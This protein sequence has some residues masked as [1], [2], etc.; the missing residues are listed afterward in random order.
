MRLLSPSFVARFPFRLLNVHPSLLPAFPGLEAQAQAIR[1]GARISG[2][3]VHFVDAGTDT[4]PVI[5]Q[6]AVPVLPSD[7]P[8]ELA[9][10]ILSVE[11]RI[12]AQAVRAVLVGGWSMQG[13]RFVPRQ[14]P[15]LEGLSQSATGTRL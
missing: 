12:Y 4:G 11:H 9:A 2:A 6:E 5:L 7:D 13:R 1:Y 8:S 14:N 3:T 10:R 15:T